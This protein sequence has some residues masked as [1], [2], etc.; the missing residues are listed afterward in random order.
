MSQYK[1]TA[2][3]ALNIRST[4]STS[5]TIVGTYKSGEIEEELQQAQKAVK[6]LGGKVKDV[7]KFQLPNTEMSRSFV[8]VE[9][10]KPTPKVYPRKAGTPGKEPIK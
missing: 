6:V 9:K 2:K 8:K 10:K 4:P 7:I 1:I 5:G 3:S